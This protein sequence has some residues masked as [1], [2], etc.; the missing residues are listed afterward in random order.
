MVGGRDKTKGTKG[1]GQLSLREVPSS[2]HMTLLYYMATVGCKETENI[3]FI[4]LS[5]IP[6]YIRAS[7]TKEEEKN[8][9]WEQDN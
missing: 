9:Y 2:C 4:L 8:G 6:R 1:T 3:T 5:R 7:I